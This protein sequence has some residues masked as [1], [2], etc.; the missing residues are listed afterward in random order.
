MALCVFVGER[1][2]DLPEGFDEMI[3]SWA[4]RD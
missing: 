2:M 1:P 3:D 4:K